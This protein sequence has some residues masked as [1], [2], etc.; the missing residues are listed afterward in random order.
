MQMPGRYRL[1]KKHA[2]CILFGILACMIRTVIGVGSRPLFPFFHLCKDPEGGRITKQVLSFM[3]EKMK[4]L[5]RKISMLFCL[6]FTQGSPDYSI[7]SSLQ[8]DIHTETLPRIC[9]ACIWVSEG[10]NSTRSGRQFFLGTIH[11]G[12]SKELTFLQRSLPLNNLELFLCLP[13]EH[14][15]QHFLHKQH[16]FQNKRKNFNFLGALRN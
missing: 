15:L 6:F 16:C 8:Q 5:S 9:C 10:K 4:M 12:V 1:S 11:A 7:E 2:Y 3:E 14:L 13:L